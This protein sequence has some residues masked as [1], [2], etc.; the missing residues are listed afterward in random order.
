ML[1]RIDA[2][3][4]IEDVRVMSTSSDQ[5]K[6]RD[7][8]DAAKKRGR[9]LSAEI[10]AGEEMKTS[11]EFAAILGV[12]V[13]TMNSRRRRGKLLGLNG[14][15]K[16]YRFPTWQLNKDGKPYVILDKL[17]D[18]LGGSWSVYRLLTQ[19]HGELDG[20]TGL[21]ALQKGQDARVVDLAE[22][23]GRDFS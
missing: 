5:T 11:E 13:A 17:H 9:K 10:L 14:A 19:H 20:L 16:G 12:S 21:E 7:A 1:F 6:L 2:W 8:I 22:T 4:T 3:S 15:V 18:R 23:V